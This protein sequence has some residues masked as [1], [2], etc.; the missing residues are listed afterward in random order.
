MLG[1]SHPT[2]AL[3][4]LLIAVVLSA[5]GQYEESRSLYAQSLQ[6]QE[7]NFGFKSPEVAT[8]LEEFA[9]LLHK[10]KNHEEARAM[11]KRAKSIRAET[12]YVVKAP[13]P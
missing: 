1:P 9:K 10:I 11:E 4:S 3:T 6:T 5:Q 7:Q 2:V 8:V 12:E 13:R